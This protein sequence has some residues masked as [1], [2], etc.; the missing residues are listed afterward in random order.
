MTQVSHIL[1]D[2]F[3]TLVNYSESRTDQGYHSSHAVL[4]SNGLTLGYR[5]FLDR[6]SATFRQFDLQS[7]TNHEEYSMDEV[8]VRFLTEVMGPGLDPALIRTFRDTYLQEWNKGVVYI[9]GV[10]ELLR[11]LADSYMLVLVTN[12]HSAE[13]VHGHLDN[14]NVG[15]SFS[16]V[17]TSVEHGKRKPAASIFEHAL[18]V[19]GGRN[20]TSLY[21]GDSFAADYVGAKGIGMRCL[22]VDRDKKQD[23]PKQD[24]IASVLDLPEALAMS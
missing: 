1:F 14:L 5:E 12:T 19:T 23:V 3:G 18:S 6:W 8:V 11:S 10:A 2:F 9:E 16:E 17:I 15:S 22:L 7:E 21:V 24:R 20:R 13:L 4:Q